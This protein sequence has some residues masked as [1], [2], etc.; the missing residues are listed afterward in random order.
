MRRRSMTCS[1]LLKFSSRRR[2]AFFRR[3]LF[4][5]IWPICFDELEEHDCFNTG[6]LTFWLIFLTAISSISSFFSRTCLGGGHFGGFSLKNLMLFCWRRSS[7]IPPLFLKMFGLYSRCRWF[8]P[9]MSSISTISS[10]FL[11]WLIDFPRFWIFGR[12]HDFLLDWPRSMSCLR[13]MKELLED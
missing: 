4:D 8:L 2:D 13:L 11:S 12:K 9:R 7:I 10:C 5:F 3:L 6:W 1:L